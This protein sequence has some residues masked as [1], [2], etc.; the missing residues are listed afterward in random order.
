VIV[1]LAGAMERVKDGDADM[2]TASAIVF[3]RLPEVPVTLR[4]AWPGAAEG[5]AMRL[6]VLE[7]DVV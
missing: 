4:V 6:S 3:V 7:V 5:P 2:V 1:R